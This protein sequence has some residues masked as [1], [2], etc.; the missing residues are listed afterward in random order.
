M[1]PDDYDVIHIA[2][3]NIAADGT[4]SFKDGGNSMPIITKEWIQEKINAGRIV[5]FSAGGANSTVILDTP[6]KV[7]RFADTFI[8][9]IEEY[10]VNGIDID[11]EHGLSAL[12]NPADLST[13]VQGLID[14]LDN[15]LA[16]FGGDFKLFMAPESAN[17]MGGYKTYGG[18]W[19]VYL[20]IIEHFKDR[21]TGLQ[22]QYYNAPGG[23]F[24]LDDTI[25]YHATPANIVAMTDML[26]RKV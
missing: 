18:A 10:G 12:S 2:F 14:A 8:K 7:K 6:E 20:P 17:V 23:L 26:A 4:V 16:H 25:Y 1:V 22:V 15:I 11:I 21:L 19:G 13:S 24:G 5:P 9:L 3:V